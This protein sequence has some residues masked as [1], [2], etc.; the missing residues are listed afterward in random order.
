MVSSDLIILSQASHFKDSITQFS[1]LWT[2]LS[3]DEP[4]V[5]K[6]NHIQTTVPSGDAMRRISILSWQPLFSVTSIAHYPAHQNSFQQDLLPMWKNKINSQFLITWSI[7]LSTP[8]LKWN[9]TPFSLV[10]IFP[11]VSERIY[12][13]QKWSKED[14]V[15]PWSVQFPIQIN[16][17][18][19][20][21]AGLVLG[22]RHSFCYDP[23]S[24]SVKW[25]E[26]SYLRTVTFGG[27]YSNYV[28]ISY[29]TGTHVTFL[30]VP[31]LKLL[32]IHSLK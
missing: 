4:L 9:L 13:L 25:F 11:V 17:G 2:K 31:F 19:P 3:A 5:D 21:F 7:F 16:E 30:L 23:A 22:T 28:P 27:D 6:V 29:H 24:S 10:S 20:R 8:N 12:Q 14:A 1:T 32:P 15:Y 26:D 18:S